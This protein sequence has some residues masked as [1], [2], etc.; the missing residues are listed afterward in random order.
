[1]QVKPPPHLL[2]RQGSAA[3]AKPARRKAALKVDADDEVDTDDGNGLTLLLQ[4]R[5]RPY[6]RI[7]TRA[8]SRARLVAASRP[9]DVATG[10]FSIGSACPC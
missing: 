6:Q 1:L 4:V 8:C 3:A 9:R 10:G 5:R 7:H 2:S